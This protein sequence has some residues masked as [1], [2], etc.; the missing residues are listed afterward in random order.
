M[1]I[2]NVFAQLTMFNKLKSQ[3]YK[4]VNNFSKN[5]VVS[6]MGRNHVQ[7]YG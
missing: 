1:F 7:S 4:Q 3:A 6:G 5:I 2:K